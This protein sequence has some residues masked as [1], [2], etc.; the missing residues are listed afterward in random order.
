MT[1]FEQEYIEFENVKIVAQT[2]KAALLEQ[3]DGE[4]K[5]WI[6]WSMISDDSDIGKTGEVGTVYLTKW[7]C[8]KKEIEY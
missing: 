1:E 8:D 7:I 2:D 3:L 5:E 4:F 6:P